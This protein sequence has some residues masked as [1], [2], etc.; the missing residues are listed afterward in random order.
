MVQE[1]E[2]T[3]DHLRDLG[4]GILSQVRNGTLER[5]HRCGEAEVFARLRNLVAQEVEIG[6]RVLQKRVVGLEE[7]DEAF[8]LVEGILDIHDRC[9]C[10]P[11]V[12][13]ELC[14]GVAHIFDIVD[15]RIVVAKQPGAGLEDVAVQKGVVEG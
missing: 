4:T 6:E 13:F 8:L 7:F 12:R 9:R 3:L 11:I 15:E 14:D 5:I 1:V 10:V 2:S